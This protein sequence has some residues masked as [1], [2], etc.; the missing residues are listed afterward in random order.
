M[1]TRRTALR[2]G[3]TAGLA[4]VAGATAAPAGA[5]GAGADRGELQALLDR[6]VAAGASA[7]LAEVRDSAGTWRGASGAAELGTSRPAP[8]HGRFR[9]GSTAKTFVATTVLQLADE[10]RVS[11]DGE[12]I[13]RWLPGAVPNSDRIT[14]R[15]LLQHTSGVVNHARK[16]GQR[17]PTVE[18]ILSI[19]YR[20]WSPGELLELIA[21]EPPLFEPGTS[22]SYSNTNYLLLALLIERV[23]G[24]GYRSEIAQ[25]ILGPLGLHQTELPGTRPYLT[26]PHA[27]GYLPLER[28]GQIRPVDITTYNMSRAFGA[29]EIVSTTADLNR[30]F[31][32]LLGGRLLGPGRLAEMLA[33][34]TGER[35]YALGIMRRRLPG[36]PVLWG[37]GGTVSGYETL[38]LVTRDGRTRLALSVNPWG[39]WL[40]GPPFIAPPE[41][42]IDDFVTTAFRGT[43]H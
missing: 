36:G 18:D 11:L 9:V 3:A 27:H 33:N 17:Y 24:H 7:A 19:R 41:P 1:T 10:G 2:A 26:G 4:L 39:R 37:H 28:D 42:E 30:F 16:I 32:A 29:G 5:A 14:V 15:Q 31:G 38:A 20:T 21:G 23:T 40:D 6:I 12:P 25:R 8:P 13:G 22:W 43:S 34:P 35:E